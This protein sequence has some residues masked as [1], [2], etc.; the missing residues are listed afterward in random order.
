M[1]DKNLYTEPYRLSWTDNV[2][3]KPLLPISLLV[4]LCSYLFFFQSGRLALTDPD[5][6][7]YAQTAKELLARGDHL[8]PYLYGKP[9]FEKPIL[10]YWLV[11][12]SF[13]IFGVNEFASRLPS[14]VF[15]LLGVIGIYLL[16]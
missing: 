15:G 6:A 12:L 1:S 4:V 14:G 2:L 3:K 7:F 10:F 16:G 5:E 8:T 13:K 9:Q 11:E